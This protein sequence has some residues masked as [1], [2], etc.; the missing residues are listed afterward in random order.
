MDANKQKDR[1]RGSLIGGA[2]GDA[3][4][5]P[6]EFIYSYGKI[7]AKYGNRG[8]TR[9]DTEQWWKGKEEQSGKAL[10]SDDTQMT[11]FTA[12][13]LLNA[14]ENGSAPLPSICEAYIEWYYTQ[15]GVKSKRHH[16]CWIRNIPELN[17][18]RAP[19]NTC[20][21]AIAEIISGMDPHNNSKG[22]GGVMRIAPI[23]LYGASQNRITD[24]EALDRMAADA[25]RLTHLHP[26]GYIPAALV[27]H[28]I[29]RLATDEHPEK[30]TFKDYIREGLETIKELFADQP[31]KVSKL[32]Y[33]I[34]KAIL[35]SDISTDDVITIENEIG[36][37]WVADEAAAIAIYCA[38][39]YFDNFEEA[40]IAAVNHGGDS[41]STGAV[42]GNIL[43]AALGYEAIPSYY[44][45]DLEL[46]DLILHVADD[47]YEGKNTPFSHEPDTL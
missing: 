36:G 1:I 7:Q 25:A 17:Q 32:T 12:C 10:I 38:L 43:G 40:L 8:I 39:K 6:V 33:L 37:G 35:L 22:C 44:K 41:D 15:K 14:K 3:L 26:L 19:G 24:I 34:R 20:L 21:S 45:K 13:G 29:Y 11:L 28:I 2:A 47:L 18:R 42:T 9:L 5:Y 46:H 27:S 23:A 4:G 31:E 16:E 30:E